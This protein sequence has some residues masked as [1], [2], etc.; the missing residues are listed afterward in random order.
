MSSA[1]QRLEETT[2]QLDTEQPYEAGPKATEAGPER[3]PKYPLGNVLEPLS[4]GI[5]LGQFRQ[6]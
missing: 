4:L 5:L 6:F 1:N 2:Y 3:A